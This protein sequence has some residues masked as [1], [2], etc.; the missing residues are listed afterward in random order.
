[1]DCLFQR[2]LNL[3][4]ADPRR[5]T[6]NI[7]GFTWRARTRVVN[8]SPENNVTIKPVFHAVTYISTARDR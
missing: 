4:A 5:A 7:Q 3:T 8:V 6:T 2:T 1:M